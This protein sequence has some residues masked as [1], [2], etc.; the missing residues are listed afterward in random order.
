[1]SYDTNNVNI[2]GRLVRDPE[3]KGLG[4]GK[5]LLSFS[6]ACGDLKDKTSFFDFNVWGK[7][8][9]NLSNFLHKGKQICVVGRLQQNRWQN[10]EG[11]N[12]SHIVIQANNVQLLGGN[13]GNNN[14]IPFEAGAITSD[15]RTN[16][17]V[18]F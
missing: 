13:N 17:D 5:N 2:I 12:R 8:A 7:Q 9:E 16:G 11:Q 3:K 15:Q 18:P 10:K 1:M 4:D 14:D 6:I